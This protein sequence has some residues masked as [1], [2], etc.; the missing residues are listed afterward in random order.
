ME[1]KQVHELS[2][3]WGDMAKK[4]GEGGFE[5]MTGQQ[6]GAAYSIAPLLPGLT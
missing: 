5:V 6:G 3:V 4:H 1:K 2:K